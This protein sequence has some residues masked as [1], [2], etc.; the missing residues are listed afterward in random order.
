MQSNNCI[1]NT[2]LSD[3]V[4]MVTRCPVTGAYFLQYGAFIRALLI[5]IRTAGAEA[6]A[7]RR[8]DRTG[9]V[10]AERDPDG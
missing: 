7:G 8:I 4:K 10:T 6:A 1:N 9:Y 5:G 2:T 3:F